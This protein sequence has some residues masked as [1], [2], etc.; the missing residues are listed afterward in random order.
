MRQDDVR[1]RPVCITRCVQKT[2]GVQRRSVNIGLPSGLNP[3]SCFGDLLVYISNHFGV[4]LRAELKQRRAELKRK[5]ALDA[6]IKQSDAIDV[7]A[8]GNC[9][10]RSLAV[11]G[12]RVGGRDY[13]QLRVEVE[14]ELSRRPGPPG[15]LNGAS[16]QDT[17]PVGGVVEDGHGARDELEIAAMEKL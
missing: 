13:E 11:F 6:E 4:G 3:V 2:L 15:F 10:I 9:L 17:G 5:P 7:P 8:D 1:R 14:S 12:D 16:R